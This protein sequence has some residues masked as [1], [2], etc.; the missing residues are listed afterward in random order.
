MKKENQSILAFLG[1]AAQS[2]SLIFDFKNQYPQEDNQSLTP[3]F[4]DFEKI[5]RNPETRTTI[6]DIIKSEVE[7]I[8][9]AEIIIGMGSVGASIATLIAELFGKKLING[10]EIPK[11]ATVGKCIVFKDQLINGK[12]TIGFIDDLQNAGYDCLGI[13]VIFNENLVITEERFQGK[14]GVKEAGNTIKLKKP[15]IIKNILTPQKIYNAM[16]SSED[17]FVKMLGEQYKQIHDFKETE[18][19]AVAAK[20]ASSE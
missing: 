6:I 19:F 13:F 17:P 15:C 9:D 14:T 4:I 11:K 12:K 8:K 3:L 1:Q 10:P 5:I 18:E 2:K 16:N 7:F 20:S